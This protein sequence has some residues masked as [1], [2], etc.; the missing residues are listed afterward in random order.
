METTEKDRDEE[1]VRERER[2]RERGRESAHGK[3]KDIERQET[4]RVRE[5]P[6]KM[7]ILH[8][9]LIEYTNNREICPSLN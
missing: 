9:L 1:T 4:E 2:E 6:T 3:K 7:C 5:R 8:M